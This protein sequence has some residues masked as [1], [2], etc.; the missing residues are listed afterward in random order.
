MSMKTILINTENV[1]TNKPRTF[2]LTLMKILDLRISNKHLA[3]Q[4]LTIYYTYTQK[5]N[6]TAQKH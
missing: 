2:V 4:N 1:K 5:Y 3:L 6:T